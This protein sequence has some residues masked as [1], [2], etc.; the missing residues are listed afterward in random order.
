MMT[1]LCFDSNE[2]EAVNDKFE[3]CGWGTFLIFQLMLRSIQIS[4]WE[5]HGKSEGKRTHILRHD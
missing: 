5:I 3:R 1:L 4:S 2:M